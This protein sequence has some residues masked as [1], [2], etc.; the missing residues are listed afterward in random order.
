M[1]QIVTVSAS[2]AAYV[3][4]AQKPL[5]RAARNLT[6]DSINAVVDQALQDGDLRLRSW[7]TVVQPP[8]LALYFMTAEP[9][10]HG[11]TSLEAAEIA[12][13]EQAAE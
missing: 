6:E 9:P 13:V 1:T 7:L 8:A 10:E 5:V 4:E 11:Q 12:Y 2:T 3:M